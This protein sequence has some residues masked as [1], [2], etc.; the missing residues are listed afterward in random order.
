MA[1]ILSQ[2]ELDAL[3]SGVRRTV[4]GEGKKIKRYDFKHPDKF[5]KDHIRTLQM[6]HDIDDDQSL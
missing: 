3:L 6:L 4:K 1:E 2:K 5:S